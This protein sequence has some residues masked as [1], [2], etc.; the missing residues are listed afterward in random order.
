M[1]KSN[2]KSIFLNRVFII[3]TTGPKFRTYCTVNVNNSFSLRIKNIFLAGYKKI[4]TITLT[5]LFIYIALFSLSILA[6][7]IIQFLTLVGTHWHIAILIYLVFSEYMEIRV[8]LHTDI[9]P[10][11]NTIEDSSDKDTVL[12]SESGSEFC[13]N[14]HKTIPEYVFYG[15][16]FFTHRGYE[17]Y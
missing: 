17:T 9:D 6:D 1:N 7:V 4:C 11:E 5:L 10:Y 16:D 14:I 12:E 8:N 3:N 2:N 13:R 15:A